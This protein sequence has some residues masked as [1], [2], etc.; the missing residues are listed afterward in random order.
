[1]IK[2]LYPK[3]FN[4]FFIIN[5]FLWDIYSGIYQQKML[6]L[7]LPL[8]YFLCNINYQ[9]TENKSSFE[10]YLNLYEYKKYFKVTII[11][12]ISF[13][14]L[15]LH[16]LFFFV[17]FGFPHEIKSIIKIFFI[18][19]TIFCVY[20]NFEILHKNFENI[21]IHSIFLI[22][23]LFLIEIL[24]NLGSGIFTLNYAFNNNCYDDFFSKKSFVFMEGSHFG[25][26]IPA[27]II[28]YLIIV[29]EKKKKFCLL[30]PNYISTFFYICNSFI[31]YFRYIFYFWIRNMFFIL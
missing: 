2:K 25:M 19:L 14:I 1:M 13:L 5:F 16:K 11:L 22:S 3:I 18:I 4:Y 29:L 27:L 17:S 31:N 24:I 23:I 26:V 6:I 28:S 12:I 9:N 15:I 21:V 10:Y 20:F 8:I 7:L 30:Y